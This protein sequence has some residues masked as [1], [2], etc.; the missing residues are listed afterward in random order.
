[1]GVTGTFIMRHNVPF[2]YP[3]HHNAPIVFIFKHNVPVR[4]I[5]ECVAIYNDGLATRDQKGY[6]TNL[7]IIKETIEA[8]EKEKEFVCYGLGGENKK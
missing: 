3:I 8:V 6:L 1:M 2:I 7:L 4:V 5:I